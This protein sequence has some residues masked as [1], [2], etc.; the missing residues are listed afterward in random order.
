MSRGTLFRPSG[1]EDLVPLLVEVNGEWGR[2]MLPPRTVD[3]RS[4]R[5]QRY[6]P[7]IE[8]P[9]ARIE[10]WTNQADPADSF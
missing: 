4:Y 9:F 1:A 5:I 10:R 7:R 8:G 6:R 2:E 3:G